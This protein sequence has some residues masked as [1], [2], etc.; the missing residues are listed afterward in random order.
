[1]QNAR[2]KHVNGNR[3]KKYSEMLETHNHNFRN[4]FCFQNQAAKAVLHKQVLH[5]RHDG[6]FGA[7]KIQ[8]LLILGEAE[9]LGFQVD[10]RVSRKQFHHV[11]PATRT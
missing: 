4:F 10:F 2:Q 3:A 8:L 9:K 1:M 7:D 5:I 6:S 11:P